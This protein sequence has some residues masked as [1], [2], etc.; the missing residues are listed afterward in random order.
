MGSAGECQLG[1]G[2]CFRS[3][4]RRVNEQPGLVLYH[5]VWVR[6]HNRL[7]AE[8]AKINPDWGDEQLFQSARNILV[9]ELQHITYTE[10]LPLILGQKYMGNIL[11]NDQ[12]N[13]SIDATVSNAFAAAVFRF[14]HSMITEN[15]S[16]ADSACP[17]QTVMSQPLESVFFK[18]SLV[19]DPEKLVMSL[20]G[21][22]HEVSNKPGPNFASSVNG[23]LFIHRESGATVGLD[24]VS[25][26]IHRGR[27]HGL[28][29][30]NYFRPLCGLRRAENFTDL[31]DVMTQNQAVQLSSVYDHVDDVDLYIAGMME[32]P[33]S[34][35]LLGPTFSCIISDQMFR[36]RLGDR[37]FYSHTSSASNFNQGW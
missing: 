26:N 23:K 19:T 10:Y 20:A 4:D 33:V 36:T 6:E 27:D 32:S 15:V 13:S 21:L 28:P 3:G 18:P 11:R 16:M 29:G 8:L 7:A 30:Y 1:E 22:S 34:G 25:I 37:F 35:S 2:L 17:R 12:Y 5:V 31:V 24:L 9:A 14:G